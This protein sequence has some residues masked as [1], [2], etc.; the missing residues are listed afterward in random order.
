MPT[1]LQPEVSG[2]FVELEGGLLPAC[3]QIV[4]CDFKGRMQYRT[5]IIIRQIT[6]NV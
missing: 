6:C 2:L 5:Q 1:E 4:D 3:S